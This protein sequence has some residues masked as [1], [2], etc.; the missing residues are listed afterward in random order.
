MKYVTSKKVGGLENHRGKRNKPDSEDKYAEY[1]FFL[2]D[3]EERR[4]TIWV[5]DPQRGTEKD[6]ERRYNHRTRNTCMNVG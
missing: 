2:T 3:H 1:R 5:G 4:K 6:A